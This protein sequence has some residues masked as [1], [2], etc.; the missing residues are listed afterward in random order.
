MPNTVVGSLQIETTFRDGLV[1]QSNDLQIDVSRF[2]YDL[3]GNKGSFDGAL[4]VSVTDDETNYVYVDASATLQVSITGWPSGVMHVR[5]AKVFASNGTITSITDVRAFLTAADPSLSGDHGDLTGLGDDDHSQYHND[6][7]GDARYYPQSE[8]I[9]SSTGAPDAGK[10][11][12]LDSEGM[13]DAT[14][15]QSSDINH[16]SL[17]NVQPN[18]HHTRL[19][20][21]AS[22]GDHTSATLAQFAGLISDADIGP[23]TYDAVVD[24]GGDGDFTS[25]A[26][27]FGSGAKMVFVRN[28]TYVETSDINVPEDGGILGEAPGKARIVLAGAS[29]KIFVGDTSRST[30]T[31]TIAIT[32][33]TAAVTGTGTSFTSVQDGDWIRI[34]HIWHEIDTVTDDTH[35][36]LART[37][38]G[39]TVSGLSFRAQSMVQG[40]LLQ[41]LVVIG[42]GSDSSA[43][44]LQQCMNVVVQTALCVAC[45]TATAP[46]VHASHSGECF[47]LGLIVKDSLSDAVHIESSHV[48]Q[49]TSCSF[50]NSNGH[51][52]EIT[53]CED[54]IIDTTNA[55]A[56]GG[57]GIRL[58]GT[59]THVNITD[60]LSC[61]NVGK[62]I[63]TAGTTG[64]AVIDSCTIT[65]NEQAGLDFDGAENI[66]S[67]NVIGA[68]G[69]GIKAGDNGAI[70][71]N[72][73]FDNSG[74][75]IGAQGDS[76]CVIGSNRVSGNSGDGIAAG[77]DTS[78]HGNV[79]SGNMGDGIDTRGNDNVVVNGNRCMSNSG[80][81]VLV[82]SGSANC[83]VAACNLLGNTSGSLQ[84]DGT[85]TTLS[86]NET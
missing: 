77:P 25:I 22:S 40:A 13:V 51:G 5:L 74:V 59:T 46:A 70:I 2:Q 62:G 4:G 17:S 50:V 26:E 78:V 3:A 19:H 8:H 60:S 35:L 20:S 73:I 52:L 38:R 76:G 57:N 14:M 71:G 39:K 53:D 31:G 58:L 48:M 83:I 23:R 84:D 21:I 12:V 34:D 11:I 66:V 75:G 30:E 37:Y 24:S 41:N 56:N 80:Y 65:G 7:R 49:L 33:G 54:V 63:S 61:S 27:A 28:G 45:G 9:S 47:L 79:V 44:I 18:Q 36:T 72:R 67:N 16:A 42:Y 32:S 82:A 10:P 64:S 85:S 6:T 1:E 43:I 55:M 29:N 68:N 69:S 86:A 15:L 81:G